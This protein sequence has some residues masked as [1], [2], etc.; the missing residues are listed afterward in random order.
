MVNPRTNFARFAKAAYSLRSG[1]FGHYAARV[2]PYFYL[3]IQIL[4]NWD[5]KIEAGQE[6][7][8]LKIL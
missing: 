1:L 6:N 7:K 3:I 5:G 8:N 4:R 2:K